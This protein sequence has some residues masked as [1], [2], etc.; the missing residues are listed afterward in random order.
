MT[1]RICSIA[2]MAL[3]L[4][5]CASVF[6]TYFNREIQENV[7]DPLKEQEAGASVMGMTATRRGIVVRA[8]SQKERDAGLPNM[9]FCAEPPPDVAQSIATALE[10]KLSRKDLGEA[11]ISDSYKTMIENI[12]TR[13]PLSE[14]YRTAVYSI[15]Q[16]HLNGAIT[17]EEARVAFTEV[18]NA[19]IQGLVAAAGKEP[20]RANPTSTSTSSATPKNNTVTNPAI[21]R[22]TGSATSDSKTPPNAP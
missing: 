13:T 2:L 1:H 16:L 19:V 20:I 4:P 9:M 10:L 3:L 22:G 14:T 12:S 11:A 5:G 18:T 7:I 21:T 6:T 17:K 8:T 15:C